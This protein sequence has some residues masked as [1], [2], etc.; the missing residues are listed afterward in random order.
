MQ[1]H[2]TIQE[3]W[4]PS[5]KQARL[6]QLAEKIEFLGEKEYPAKDAYELHQYYDL[7]LES[8]GLFIPDV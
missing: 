4:L 3:P 5:I 6:D 7:M 8:M 2:G 1:A